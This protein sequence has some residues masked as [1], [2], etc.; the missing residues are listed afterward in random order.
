MA[1]VMQALPSVAL[2]KEGRVLL[3]LTFELN[4]LYY[5]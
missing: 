4:K 5:V 2:A 1:S 3:L